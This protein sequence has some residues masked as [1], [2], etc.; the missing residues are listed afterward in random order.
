[1]NSSHMI[2]YQVSS[3][4]RGMRQKIGLAK[5]LL[6]DPEVLILDEPAGGLDPQARIEMRKIIVN[7]KSL[8]KTIMLSSHI[9]PELGTIC[10][11]VAI[12]AKARLRAFGTME[13]VTAN[14]KEKLRYSLTVDGN[15]D[16]AQSLLQQFEN[17]ENINRSH[18]EVVFTFNGSRSDIADII[19]YLVQNQV[20]I[21]SLSEQQIDLE[22]VFMKV[23]SEEDE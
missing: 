3:L 14:L 12:V 17:V 7:L 1:M 16:Q 13:E 19:N 9:L 11:L 8:G 21:L 4:S 18:S 15:A 2:D 10:D 20:R 6:H 22:T 5:T 23:T